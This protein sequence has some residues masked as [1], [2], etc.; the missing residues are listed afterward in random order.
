M[1]KRFSNKDQITLMQLISAVAQLNDIEQPKAVSSRKL[2]NAAQ[3]GRCHFNHDHSNAVKNPNRSDQHSKL[4]T[5]DI[6]LQQGRSVK[7]QGVNSIDRIGQHHM[8][9]VVDTGVSL[10]VSVVPFDVRLNEQVQGVRVSGDQRFGLCS[11]ADIDH[12]CNINCGQAAE[13]IAFCG[14]VH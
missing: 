13:G 3:R 5:I 4:A 12:G 8:R 11:H 14:C 2:H 9:D 7:S 6:D 1:A 10:R